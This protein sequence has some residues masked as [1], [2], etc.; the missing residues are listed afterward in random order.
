MI[1]HRL[2]DEQWERIKDPFDPPAKTGRPPRD[3]RELIDG[4]L[5]VLNAGAPWRDLLEEL[6]PWQAVWHRFNQWN[7]DG[8]LDAILGELIGEIEINQELWC[9]DSTTVRA[10]K[11]AAGGGKKPTKT[12]RRTP[13]PRGWAPAAAV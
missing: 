10:H 1:R 5:W 13:R 4:I 11:Y 12:S 2:K 7:G 8:T 3:R 9:I 6:G